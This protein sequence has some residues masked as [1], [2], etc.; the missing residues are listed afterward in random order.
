MSTTVVVGAGLIGVSTAFALA[1]RGVAVT[2]VDQQDGPGQGASNANGGM[3]T[4]SM[5][6]P[7]NAPGVWRD[8]LRWYGRDNAP[9]LLRTKAIPSLAGWGLRFLSATSQQHYQRA[10][11]L[12]VRL[13]LYS[14]QVLDRWRRSTNL[15]YD[16]AQKGTAKIYR[17]ADAFRQGVAKAEK[18]KAMGVSYELLSPDALIEREPALAPIRGALSGTVYFPNDEAGDAFKFTN[19]LLRETAKC[20]VRTKWGARV[21]RLDIRKRAVAGVI[22]ENGETIAADR[23]VIASG[24]HAPRLAAQAGVKLA[25]KPVKGYSVTFST[26]H[27]LSNE[28]LGIPIVDDGLHAAVTPLGDRV[29]VSGTAEF[30]GFDSRL[31]PARIDNLR[32]ILRAILPEQSQALEKDELQCWANFRPMHAYGAPWIGPARTKGVYLN[33]GHGHLGW[34]LAAGSGE[35]LAQEILGET[36]GFDLA[37]YHT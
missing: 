4:P 34:T 9:M 32:V 21:K 29:R 33:A 28:R 26:K 30:T 37:D 36:S 17:G 18:M 6:D 20:G 7:W 22:L 27:L 25:V 31:D 2:I 19:E 24:A 5:A 3:L 16:G 35:A 8:L 14:L 10:T 15:S 13:G 23:V 1:R 12:N 11:A